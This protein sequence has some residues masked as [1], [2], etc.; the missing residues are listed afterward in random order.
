MHRD[1]LG[2]TLRSM[3]K[4][5][6]KKVG[7]TAYR[8]LGTM[9]DGVVILAPKLAPTHF[10]VG[11]IRSTIAKLVRATSDAQRES[12]ERTGEPAED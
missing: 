8:T 3:T 1:A 6:V 12:R 2:I 11:Q 9:P 4:S 5:D 7:T 10:K